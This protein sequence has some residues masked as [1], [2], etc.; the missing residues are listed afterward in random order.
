MKNEKF[1]D[2]GVL[3]W[4]KYRPNSSLLLDP[5]DIVRVY[6]NGFIDIL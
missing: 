2:Y 1:K 3:Q 5:K 4:L 6:E